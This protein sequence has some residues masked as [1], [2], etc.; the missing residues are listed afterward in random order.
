MIWGKARAERLVGLS[1][2]ALL[3]VWLLS[4]PASAQQ[5]T[6]GIAGLVTDTS[7]AVLPGV[8]VEAASPVL[9]E[10]VR[11]VVTDGEGRYNVIDLRPGTYVVTFSLTGFST[12]RREGI[13]LPGGFTA[14]V[15]AQLRVGSLE[16]AI[17]VSGAAPLV[18]VQNVRTAAAVTAEVLQ[19]LPS[20]SKSFGSLAALVPGINYQSGASVSGTKGLFNM[21]QMGFA[22]FHGKGGSWSRFDGM[23]TQGAAGNIGAVGYV[24]NAFLAEEMRVETGGGSADSN[25]SAVTFDMIPKEGGNTFSWL[26]YG[27]YAG[28][29]LQSKNLTDALRARGLT[30][31]AEVAYLF[32]VAGTLG[33]P[34][35][36]DKLW[37]FTA[38]RGTGD[39]NFLPGNFFN[40][41]QGTPF[42]TPDP[43]RPAYSNNWVRSDALRMTWQVSP[44]N[45]VNIFGDNQTFCACRLPGPNAPE[46]QSQYFFDPQGLYMA[47]WSSPV[48]NRLL[49]QAAASYAIANWNR[50]PQAG[51]KPGDIAITDLLTNRQYNAYSSIAVGAYG[52]TSSKK[53]AQ[54]GSA[55]YV[56]GSHAFKAGF[57]LEEAEN[58]SDR[59]NNGGLD[60]QFRGTVP[61]QITQYAYP[62]NLRDKLKAD[63]GIYAQD[64]WTIKRLTLNLG[65]RFDYFNTY[66]PAQHADAGPFVPERNFAPVY[67][68][69]N[70]KTLNPR[71]GASYNLF[72]N[73]RTALKGSLGR[74]NGVLGVG[75]FVVA[76]SA[77]PFTTS[78]QN[79]TRT[80]NNTAGD[81]IPHC[82]LTNFAA[83][84]E[85]GAISN[86]NFGKQNPNA[87]RLADE[88]LRGWHSRDYTWDVTAE[89]QQQVGASLSVT[90]GYYQNN[91]G[92]FRVTDNLAVRPADYSPYC[93]TAPTTAPNGTFLPG[94][95]GYPVCGLYDVSLQ[96][97]G[98]VDNLVRLAS[99][100]G[101]QTLVNQ[102]IGLNVNGRYGRGI[103]I[104]G[105]LD[106][107]R[108]VSDRCFV[109]NSPQELKYCRTVMPFRGQT[110]IKV[111]GSL[112]LPGDVVVSGSLS[113]YNGP[114]ILATYAATNAEVTPTLGRNL[115]A[116][117]TRPVC[118]ATAVGIPLIEPGTQF[119][120]WVNG[121]D[122]RLSKIVK[123]TPKMRLQGNLDLYNV[124]N[125]AGVQTIT[126]AFG[127]QWRRPIQILDARLI[128]F[129]GQ[130]TF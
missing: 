34:I 78:V 45:K 27:H 25:T 22:T 8:T 110:Q 76:E 4:S 1:L 54:R 99:H 21:A 96:K 91:T 106:T 115:A 33:G 88:V 82:D 95:G 121:L 38:H 51:V 6:S 109:V 90:A 19:A 59:V 57:Y 3:S 100:Y 55:S 50:F 7:G 56:T 64:Q 40:K 84:G 9:I 108:T 111:F 20:G 73:G 49:L 39:K 37:F 93:I 58:P 26:F 71:F 72:G 13:E 75:T 61:V 18:D 101:K 81:Y 83:N 123:L 2:V 14:T 36:K 12:V 60:Y 89:V 80:W 35:R 46:A 44:K 119:E 87:T 66:A 52:Y 97:F 120:P 31:V 105:G 53:W 92:N 128:Q 94:G 117:G 69:P 67:D 130:L 68:I 126:T 85:C 112:P 15:N 48:T 63:L 43:S 114:Q 5:T 74:Y 11:T 86:Q 24:P 125:G 118:T 103:Q 17:T 10:K 65:L 98:Q 70:W 104:G 116:C 23:G 41:T 77:N 32:D 16:E 29:G 113:S 30:T 62:I 102:F 28:G 122:L 79:V 127:R 107:G 129:G 124:F 47:S 42:Y